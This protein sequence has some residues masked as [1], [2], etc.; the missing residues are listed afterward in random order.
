MLKDK[1]LVKILFVII[2]IYFAFNIF[3]NLCQLGLY[4]E[5]TVAYVY[6]LD[7]GHPYSFCRLLFFYKVDS[8]IY[9]NRF[10]TNDVDCN[11]H[12][13]G[14]KYILNFSSK[15]PEICKFLIR[16]KIVNSPMLDSIFY[17]EKNGIQKKK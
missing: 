9:L 6:E 8:R 5:S 17:S 1:N 15:N 14:D 10:D 2:A 11:K 16:D 3:R 12:A 4:G 13:I 7:Y